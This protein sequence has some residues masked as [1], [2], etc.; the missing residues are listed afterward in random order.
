VSLKEDKFRSKKRSCKERAAVI[1]TLATTILNK[2]DCQNK[3]A[4]LEKFSDNFDDL[5]MKLKLLNFL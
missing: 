4:Q 1:R 3:K 5:I 2:T